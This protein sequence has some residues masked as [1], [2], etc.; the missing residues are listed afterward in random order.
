MYCEITE[1][2]C[3]LANNLE[4]SYTGYS[5]IKLHELEGSI[6]KENDTSDE[7]FVTNEG[8]LADV[9]VLTNMYKINQK[10]EKIKGRATK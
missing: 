9:E 10:N 2:F 5:L 6:R 7:Y 3:D 8:L 4:E 1:L